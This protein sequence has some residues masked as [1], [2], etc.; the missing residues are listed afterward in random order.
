MPC[1]SGTGETAMTPSHYQQAVFDS[2]EQ[3][4][5]NLIVEA[6]AGGGKTSTML[7]ALARLTDG[8]QWGGNFRA[9]FVAFNR[10]I[11]DELKRKIPPGVWAK[12]F[13][14]IGH[15][16]LCRVLSGKTI[17]LDTLKTYRIL[18]D[19]FGR[20][21]I[22]MQERKHYGAGIQRWVSLA[23]QAGI[24]ALKPNTLHEWL[25]IADHF[26]IDFESTDSRFEPDLERAYAIARQVLIDSSVKAKTGIVDFD[27]Q[28]YLPILWNVKF[29]PQDFLFVDEAQDV[30]AIQRALIQRV[31]SGRG[32]LIAV[33]DTKQA[34]YGF[35]GADSDA[36]SLLQS[37][38]RAKALPLSIC[39]RC[40]RAIVELAQS[41][42]PQIE[43]RENAPDGCV[44][45]LT[46]YNRSTFQQGDAI[47]CRN[48]KPLV[49]MVFQMIRNG[50]GATI[51]GREIGTGLIILIDGFVKNTRS[52]SSHDIVKAIHEYKA[53]EMTKAIAAG[54]EDKAQ[55]IEDR[56]E[57][58]LIIIEQVECEEHGTCNIHAVIK[59]IEKLFSDENGM[60]TLSTIHRAKGLEWDRVFFLD[61]GLLPSPWA[62]Q[63]W[64]RQQE[65]NLYYV[66]VTR[67]RH[68]LYFIESNQWKERS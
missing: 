67:A 28:L 19:L 33:G 60:V 43:A 27:D 7:M 24:G 25:S 68:A 66:A 26:D 11:A 50:I 6:V 65:D 13:N 30:N 54:K 62:R 4:I 35:R 23:K 36:M 61:S 15:G 31:L 5:D 32:R 38:F 45:T 20:G 2:I 10:A 8:Y 16:A 57:T 14:G 34:I 46:G 63:Q 41:V 22:T 29:W 39:Y 59:R 53:R 64:Q 55:N 18:D 49:E 40:D 58:L 3:T 47:L 9:T 52:T 42:V 1:V 21:E 44:E 37:E 51:R 17:T 12:T 48:T 56:T